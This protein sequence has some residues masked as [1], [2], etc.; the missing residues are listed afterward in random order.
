MRAEEAAIRRAWRLAVLLTGDTAVAEWL[1]GDITRNTD[2]SALPSADHLDRLIILRTRET[3]RSDAAS[4]RAPRKRKIHL[5]LKDFRSAHA[6]SRQSAETDEIERPDPVPTWG[7]QVTPAAPGRPALNQPLM[8]GEAARAS[9]V[10]HAIKR[11]LMEAWILTEI[12][13][14]NVLEMAR[15]MDCSKQ[16]VVR[17]AQEARKIMERELDERHNRAVA[18]LRAA[19]LGLDADDFIVRMRTAK[20][21]RRVHTLALW[22]LALL[23][24]AGIGAGTVIVLT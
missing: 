8:T 22:I 6:A 18:D 10:L 1:I 14:K 3:M 23:F 4:R 12:D 24:I 13:G 2:L 16:A 21:A 9:M 5:R 11:Q 7:R 20:R 19:A 17:H 15:A